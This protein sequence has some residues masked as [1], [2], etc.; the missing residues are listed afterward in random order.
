MPKSRLIRSARPVHAVAGAIALAVPSSALALASGATSHDVPVKPVLSPIGSLK[1][2]STHVAYGRK[3][4]VTGATSAAA[5]GRKVELELSNPR[6]PHTFD[7][8][9]E[10]ATSRI[11]THGHFRL[12]APLRESGMLRVIAPAGAPAPSLTRRLGATGAT[13]VQADLTQARI[14]P[15]TVRSVTVGAKLKIVDSSTAVVGSQ[16]ASIHGYLEPGRSGRTVAAQALEHGRWQNLARARTGRYGGFTVRFHAPAS[17]SA[18]RVRFAG[19]RQNTQKSI[20]AGHV[21]ALAPTVASWYYD[22]GSTACGFHAYYGVANLSLPCGTHV[23]M[24]SGGHTVV[25]TV[26]DRGPYVGGR[27]YDLNQNVAGALGFGGVGV[28]YASIQ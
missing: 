13:G 21:V 27:T 16:K 2:D 19:D 12:T 24:S 26:D 9:R 1:L 22:A 14:A 11:D 3:V 10:L 4:T 23:T 15:A 7:G 17:G 25:A 8:W 18:L 20:A 6:V 5:A 28:I